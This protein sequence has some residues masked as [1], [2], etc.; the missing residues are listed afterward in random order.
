MHLICPVCKCE[1]HKEGKTAVCSN[2]H[3]FDYAKQGYL[4]LYLSNGKSHGD[5]KES[6]QARTRFLER[7]HYAFLKHKLKELTEQYPHDITVDLACGQ[8]YYTSEL[9][10]NEKYGFDLSKDA[11]KYAARKDPDT[12]YIVASIFALPFQSGC[13]DI[14]TT[15][16]AP[17]AKDEIERILKPGGIFISVTPAEDHLWQLKET[18]YE[19]P[20]LNTVDD[21]G[22]ETE[23]IRIEE[24]MPLDHETLMDL[25]AMTPYYYHTS[26]KDRQKLDSIGHLDVKASFIIRIAK[27]EME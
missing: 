17:I 9:A 5:S 16:F 4:N 22:F 11:L 26:E 14:V 20:Y 13:A 2:R 19:T 12:N 3:S 7:D 25:F 27:K 18:L 6:M 15:C 21:I 23:E 24:T 8:G 10:G 1:L